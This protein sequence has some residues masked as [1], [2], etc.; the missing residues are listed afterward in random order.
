MTNAELIKAL[1]YCGQE[2][3]VIDCADCERRVIENGVDV[4]CEGRL[5]RDAADALEAADEMI[6]DCTAA[7]DALDDS[8]DAYIKANER[9]KKRIAELEAQA[10]ALKEESEAY[11]FGYLDGKTESDRQ[12]EDL[13][14]ALTAC[15]LRKDEAQ[16]PKE[17]EWIVTTE[18]SD[19][20]AVTSHINCSKCGFYWREP[21]H[22][23]VF[24]RCPNCGARMKGEQE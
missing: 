17:G 4:D 14:T 13:Q 18:V 10:E 20:G 2:Q 16:L 24:K 21:K 22:G 3:D 19:D 23:K 6:A 11:K 15:R 1:R 5:L 9:L 7:I 8:N 12:I